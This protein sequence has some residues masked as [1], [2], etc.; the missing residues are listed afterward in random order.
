MTADGSATPPHRFEVLA[1][2]AV[3]HIELIADDGEPHRVRAKEQLA[4]FD[5]VQTDV[6]RQRRRAAAVP[7]GAM[8][9]FRRSGQLSTVSSLRAVSGEL[10]AICFAAGHIPAATRR[11]R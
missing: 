3:A 1:A 6:G 4:V 5:C 10:K 11:L 8:A 7:A 2:V 9:S